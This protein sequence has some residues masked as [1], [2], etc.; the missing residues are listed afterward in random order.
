[1]IGKK[2]STLN[3]P[4][5]G[6]NFLTL[7]HLFFA[8]ADRQRVTRLTYKKVTQYRINGVP[9]KVYRYIAE[10][11]VRCPTKDKISHSNFLPF[12][13]TIWAENGEKENYK[14]FQS[15]HKA[16]RKISVRNVQAEKNCYNFIE[17][18]KWATKTD[19]WPNK[20]LSIVQHILN[21]RMLF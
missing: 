7:I 9:V 16:S 18:E 8:C 21:N 10:H 3:Y 12:D 17:K 6:W 2:N 19:I 14:P 15:S 13:L 20:F 5:F 4:F 1:M 11:C